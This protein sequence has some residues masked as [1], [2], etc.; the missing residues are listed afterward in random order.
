MDGIGFGIAG[1]LGILGGGTIIYALWGHIKGFLSRIVSRV[2]VTAH[3]ED[4]VST[5]VMHYL[6]ANAKKSP[7]GLKTFGGTTEYVRPKRRNQHIG[8]EM[9]GDGGCMFWMGWTPIWV[10]RSD[11][12]SAKGIWRKER[13]R[14]IRGTI[15]LD[16]FIVDALEFANAK[17][18]NDKIDRFQ[19]HYI[20]GQQMSFSGEKS[21][22]ESF[23]QNS[24]SERVTD[25]YAG[26]RLLRWKRDELGLK[27]MADGNSSDLLI[28]SPEV[29]EAVKEARFWKD[30]EEWY[31]DRKIAWKRGF[32][33]HGRPG[34]GKTSLA[35]S[36]AEDLNLPVY[37]YDMSTL[38]NDE[39]RE[40]WRQMLQDV[41]CMALIEDLDSVFDG[42]ENIAR[43][44]IMGS[45]LTFDCLLNCIDGIEKS[46]GLFLIVTTNAIDKIDDAI[47]KTDD[48]GVASRPGRIDRVLHMTPPG[49]E[50]MKELTKRIM[51]EFPDRWDEIAERAIE[52]DY[53]P[54]QVENICATMALREHFVTLEES[55][56]KAKVEVGDLGAQEDLQ[57]EVPRAK[58]PHP[59][60]VLRQ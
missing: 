16:K 38:S 7:Y 37:V 56:M 5:C 6:F 27:K 43:Q 40:A 15:D 24:I 47:A 44:S 20:A 2:I 23:G 45:P 13:M 31:R 33:L 29:M 49:L 58:A 48:D 14:F 32:L 30:S 9:L 4:R 59:D 36:L 34:T 11:G 3:I 50:G 41:P 35:R 8:Y 42:R 54:A 28:L 19:V 39:F 60:G 21:N 10:S 55:E 17:A 51:P 46:D 26:L 1:G 18:M 25:K 52:K 53:T 12:D 22:K 57:A